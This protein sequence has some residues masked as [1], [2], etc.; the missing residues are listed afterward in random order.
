MR[1]S[2]L[3]IRQYRFTTRFRGFDP[4][5]V[6]VFLESVVADLE[7]VVREN[8]TLRREIEKL[9]RDLESYRGRERTIQ[10]TLTTAQSVVDE[11]RRTAV[12]ESEV[13]VS[14]AEVRAEQILRRAE[15]QRAEIDREIAELRHLRARVEADLKKTLTGYVSLIDG[16]AS[17]RDIANGTAVPPRESEE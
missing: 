8:S 9:A 6:E 13:M 2:P 14:G 3:Q 12:K 11:L 15:E 5:E 1:L 17:A 7:E 10:E 16:F 4:R